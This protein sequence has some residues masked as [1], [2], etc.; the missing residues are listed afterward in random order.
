MKQL[1]LLFF[2][3]FS[4]S[5]ISQT[6]VLVIQ[7]LNSKFTKEIKENKRIK[8]WT[9]DGQ[10]IYGRFT[11]KDS[12]S[13]IIEEKVILLE[14]IIKMKKKSLFGTIANPI[15]IVYGSFMIIAGVVT[16]GSG[17]WGAIIG[18]SFIIGGMPLV[19]IPSISNKYS[20]Q[21]WEYSIKIR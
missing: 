17:G 10:K 16:V 14:D 19:L 8:V 13:I 12:T 7:K 11:I 4:I 3:L 20:I 6:N 21:D 2:F 1:F 5:G 9:K 18:G 15:F